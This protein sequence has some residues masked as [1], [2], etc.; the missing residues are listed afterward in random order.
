MKIAVTGKGGV[1]KTTVAALLA[2]LYAE[3]GRPV[4]AVDVDPDANLGLALGF[5]AEE[6]RGVTPVSKL[7]DLIAERTA[8]GAEGY[9]KFFKINPRVSDIPDRFSIERGGVKL[10]V[11][12]TV[13]TGGAGC[14]CPEHVVLKRVI[15]SLVLDR[16]EV[17][18]MDMEAGLEHLGRGTAGMVDAFLVVVEPGARSVQTYGQIKKLASDLGVTRVRVVANKI[19]GE[20]DR[21]FIEENI[22]ADDLLGVISYSDAVI[23]ADRQSVPPAEI[24]GGTRAE[25]GIIKEKI[26]DE[27]TV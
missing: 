21:R 24:T 25:I 14:V 3:D 11:M 16:D 9:G 6:M 13:E 7:S 20:S 26:D 22:P 15:S 4:L 23:D 2:A 1:G 27:K 19:R 8:S 12:G 5:S 17:V 10:L 18:I